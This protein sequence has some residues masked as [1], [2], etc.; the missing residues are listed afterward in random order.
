MEIF[1]MSS[2]EGSDWDSV[3][4]YSISDHFPCRLRPATAIRNLY[5]RRL[6][7]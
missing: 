3:T 2:A 7:I 5:G 1:A 4:K 6:C